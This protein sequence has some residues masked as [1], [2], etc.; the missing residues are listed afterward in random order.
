MPRT[1]RQAAQ[2]ASTD[3]ESILQV[4]LQWPPA[5]YASCRSVC[6]WASILTQVHLRYAWSATSVAIARSH[7]PVHPR[8]RLEAAAA[9]SAG[10]A[11]GAVDAQMAHSPDFPSSC[12]STPLLLNA[13]RLQ[14]AL[15]AQQQ[16]ERRHGAE[17]V[18][19]FERAVELHQNAFQ[20]G[21]ALGTRQDARVLVA[22]ALQKWAQAV[23]DAEA[24]LPDEEQSAAVEAQAHATAVQLLQRAI[25][26]LRLNVCVLQLHS[27]VTQQQSCSVALPTSHYAGDHASGEN[28]RDS[29]ACSAGFSICARGGR[30]VAGQVTVG[31]SAC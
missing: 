24:G 16:A 8:T 18:P 26:V 5:S 30:A 12:S 15:K 28:L 29:H 20:A 1:R 7:G 10:N 2:A 22:D 19:Y 6:T 9:Q 17:A 23:L 27:S 31:R 25:Q 11:Q 4:C 21:L 13:W 14:D 3:A